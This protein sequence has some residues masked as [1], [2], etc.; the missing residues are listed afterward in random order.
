MIS[1]SPFSYILVSIYF[2]IIYKFRFTF[3]TLLAFYVISF[4]LDV[5]MLRGFFIKIGDKE[6]YSE[7]IFVFIICFV[8]TIYLLR[9]KIKKYLLIVSFIFFINF[10]IGIIFTYFVPLEV[11]VLN[12]SSF[13]GWDGYVIGKTNKEISSVNF[14]RSFLFFL[15]LYS[16]S[17]CCFIIKQKFTYEIYLNFFNI[18]KTFLKFYVL[19]IL[20]ECIFKNIFNCFEII[21][22]FNLILGNGLNTFEGNE[23]RNGF[24][25]LI[26]L[27]RE[28]SHL[29]Y[30]LF[31]SLIIFAFGFK[32]FKSGNDL[33]YIVLTF[34][35]LFLT[36]AFS[37]IIYSL[38][39]IILLYTL[40]SNKLNSKNL[41][42]YL[43]FTVLLFIF[44]VIILIFFIPENIDDQFFS[45][46]NNI[47]NALEYIILDDWKFRI[48]IKSEYVRLIS[49]FDNLRSFLERP[50]FGIGA[51]V[52]LSHSGFIS[53]LSNIGIIGITCWIFLLLKSC[54]SSNV[55]SSLFLLI[56]LVIF[57][58]LF[59]GFYF[60]LLSIATVIIINLNILTTR[61][62]NIKN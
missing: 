23:I 8:N 24:Y 3:K 19:F 53:L 43:V 40:Q 20:A 21:E 4:L 27:S 5:V 46:I 60:T 62:C 52:E 9:Y 42:L 13:G 61:V 38:L 15:Q 29:A 47:I 57:A 55:K 31:V 33:F 39:V 32:H 49:I 1:F 51:G 50:I 30:T 59:V 18:I 16:F 17:T 11:K 14:L 12:C 48:S 34:L 56:L 28:P 54:I 25:V 37:S 6:Y 2:F 7:S 26:G 45:R 10:F 44:A 58:N 41:I 22:L 35:L 36:G